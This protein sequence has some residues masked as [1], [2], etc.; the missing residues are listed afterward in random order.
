ML[1][2]IIA[3]LTKRSP[4]GGYGNEVSR[5]SAFEQAPL[6]AQAIAQFQKEQRVNPTAAALQNIGGKWKE[7]TTDEERNSL[8]AA[9]NMTRKNFLQ[10]GGSPMELSSDQW[11][12][13][14]AQGFQTG[15]EEFKPGY[16]G[17]NL[18]MGQR[19][20]LAAL[21]GMFN[22]QPTWGR[23]AQESQLTGMYGG[24]KTWPR[25]AQESQLTGMFNGQ[26]TW[27]RQAQESQLTGVYGG[28]K[29]WPR[30]YQEKGLALQEALKNMQANKASQAD[31]KRENLSAAQEEIWGK[32]NEG[33]PLDQVEAW[34]V[35]NSGKYAEGGLDY[36]DLIDYAW[37]AKSG[38]KKPKLTA[39]KEDPLAANY[40]EWTKENPQ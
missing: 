8:N 37:I 2:D 36:Q 13:N 4:E 40:D 16:A 7:A 9:A 29:T 25:Q 19:T 10:S 1:Q 35:K 14:P 27:G 11:G 24:E 23:Q 17:D 6:L 20:K 33:V 3:Q 28:E 12:A 38:S 39:A 18:S 32:L 15:A 5:L 22:G 30:Q 34:I 31:V 21:T 26:P